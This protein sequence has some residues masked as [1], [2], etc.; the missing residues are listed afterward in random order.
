LRRSAAHGYAKLNH[1]SS[2]IA[3]RD[4]P[5]E[6]AARLGGVRNRVNASVEELGAGNAVVRPAADAS[7]L[8]M[9]FI[10]ESLAAGLSVADIVDAY[11]SLTE[12][13]V[14]GALAELAHQ[15]ELQPA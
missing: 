1:S 14:R 15:K 7:A 5:R 8:G 13:S 9:A 4:G 2:G 11:P 3:P 12:E 10:L 6:I